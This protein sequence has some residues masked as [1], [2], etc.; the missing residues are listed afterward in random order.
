MYS[1]VIMLVLGFCLWLVSLP[2]GVYTE[3]YLTSVGFV[4]GGCLMMLFAF[5]FPSLTNEF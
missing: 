2:Y 4:V 3:D 5:K 1:R